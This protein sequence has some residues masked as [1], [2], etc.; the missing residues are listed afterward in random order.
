MRSFY[1]IPDAALSA[2]IMVAVSVLI[3]P[4]SVFIQ[5]FKINLWDFLSSQVALWVTIF[6]SVEAGIAAGV[7]FSLV[8]L[9]FRIARPNF[10][11]LR[12][13]KD[14]PDVFVDSE[15]GTSFETVNAPHGILIFRIEESATFPN[16]DTFKTWVLEEVY[17]YTRFGGRVKAQSE[18]LWSDDLE[19]QIQ[20]LRKVAHGSDSN[21]AD[22]DLPRLRAII[23]DFA[24]V[25]NIDSTGLQSLFD[26][27]D[28]LKDYAGVTD[29]PDTF[30]EVHFVNIQ[31][32][33][34]NTLELSGLTRP[35]DPIALQKVEVLED[36]KAA[37]VDHGPSMKVPAGTISILGTSPFLKE[38]GLVHL[39]V[40]D[41][42][43]AILIRAETWGKTTSAAR[44]EVQSGSDSDSSSAHKEHKEDK[45][46]IDYV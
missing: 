21:V 31:A 26:L 4:P 45:A 34:L 5:F 38:E 13:L 9:L 41:A 16:A 12:Q 35:V 27:R 19:V 18:K 1:Y 39:T 3:S 8:V 37:N 22:D 40:R 7:G 23:F 11:V 43:D 44:D 17:K 33:V 15:V 30:F 46:E 10:H 36:S 24:A 20:K 29:Y 2:V 42:I 14:R 32:N 6:V 28:L 25:N